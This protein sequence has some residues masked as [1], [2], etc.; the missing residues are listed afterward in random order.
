M[1]SAFVLQPNTEAAE[2]WH[3]WALPACEARCQ[4]LAMRWATPRSPELWVGAAAPTT[5]TRKQC[6]RADVIY[7]AARDGCQVRGAETQL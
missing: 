6:P 3:L 7:K 2:S 1:V 5:L 4:A